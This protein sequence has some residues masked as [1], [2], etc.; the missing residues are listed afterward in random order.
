MIILIWLL[1][2]AVLLVSLKLADNWWQQS[3][4]GIPDAGPTIYTLS[5]VAEYL[6]AFAGIL[7]LANLL[8]I[9]LFLPT[10][11]KNL[12]SPVAIKYKKKAI[13]IAWIWSALAIVA[14]QSLLINIL[15]ISAT[16]FFS[17]EIFIT[18][19]WELTVVRALIL[20]AVAAI[21]IAI[22][23]MFTK[24]IS[25]IGFATV[26][27]LVAATFSALTAHAA[28]VSGHALAT[29]SGF[30]H[31]IGISVWLAGLIALLKH[32][33][34]PKVIFRKLAVERFGMLATVALLVVLVSG[35]ANSLTRIDQI[36]QLWSSNYGNLILAKF[37]LTL[38]AVV[39]AK[40][41][42]SRLISETTGSVKILMLEVILL[43]AVLA[44][45]SAAANT[46]FPKAA[47]TATTLIEQLTGYPEPAP[48]Q[49]ASAFFSFS[50]DPLTITVGFFALLIYLLG[51]VRLVKRGDKW[52]ILRT[53]TW[54]LGVVAGVFI[55]NTEISRYALVSMSAHMTQH[56]VLGMLVPI[57][58]VLGAPITLALR[59][60]PPTKLDLVGPR[61]W[62]LLVLQSYYSKLITHPLV[63]LT[64]YSGSIFVVYFSSLMTFL[65]SSHLGH[66]L[67]HIHFVLAGYLF[68]WVV[69]GTDFQPRN[70]GY[71]FKLLLVF[72]SMVIHAVFGLI[73][74]Q[75]TS[76]VGGG[77]FGKVAPVWLTDPIADQQ[78]AGS[79]AWSFGELPMLLVFL[80]LGIQ[81]AKADKQQ[82]VRLDRV[83]DNYGD[84]DRTAY[85]K[86]LQQL[87][88]K[89]DK[90]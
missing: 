44:I 52:S 77:W 26:V 18:Y 13:G 67:M 4:V 21:S 82:A 75:S 89:G 2:V 32:L 23:L 84:A 65:M 46:A 85:N 64:W 12:L 70:I 60:L 83:A 10:E 74:M 20:T 22:M 88:N 16:R 35:V 62:I 55:T 48:L 57:L 56:M 42:R 68:F 6:T 29:A 28:G 86:M 78:L 17:V 72:V 49:W 11:A 24:T 41:A 3:P 37:T 50:L 71:P 45:S 73:L 33:S 30:F 87:N 19:A 51:V 40:F 7:V 80:A 53:A 61:E 25:T 54:T 39:L 14:A 47:A 36:S 31:V 5:P 43:G 15:G 58:L 69:I 81:W 27:A 34:A 9:I 38:T 76:L 59:A 90:E 1:G 79:I 8:V 63:A 66:V